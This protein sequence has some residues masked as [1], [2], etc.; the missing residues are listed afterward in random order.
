[1]N[2]PAEVIVIKE[3]YLKPQKKIILGSKRIHAMAAWLTLAADAD[4]LELLNECVQHTAPVGCLVFEVSREINQEWNFAQTFKHPPRS[5]HTP[6]AGVTDLQSILFLHWLATF[7]RA[8]PAE[9]TTHRGCTE[10]L[11]R[12]STQIITKKKLH[13]Q[14]VLLIF[15]SFQYAFDP[16]ASH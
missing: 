2:Q 15:S 13:W 4:S 3:L 14:I 8:P 16:N 10:V 6:D 11:K 1:M 12:S 5:K 9:R 7:V